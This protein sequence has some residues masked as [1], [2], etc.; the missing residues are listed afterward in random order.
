VKGL[1]E[2]QERMRRR[3]AVAYHRGRLVD[4]LAAPQRKRRA[5][6]RP[7]SRESV[8][9]LCES[10]GK[11]MTNPAAKAA[12]NWAAKLIRDS[13]NPKDIALRPEDYIS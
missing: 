5:K 11:D 7:V 9:F 12:M 2:K 1:A 8:A 10:V 6:W 3:H 4:D 13:G